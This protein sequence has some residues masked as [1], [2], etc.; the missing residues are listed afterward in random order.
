MTD[1][2][3]EGNFIMLVKKHRNKLNDFPQTEGL[4]YGVNEEIRIFLFV[5][6]LSA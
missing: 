3:E 5:N 1:Q 4:T 6:F 2:W